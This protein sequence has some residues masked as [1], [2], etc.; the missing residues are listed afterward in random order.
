[1]PYRIE[2]NNPECA[3]GYAVVKES[4]G[5]L[6]FCHKSRREA[7]AQIAAIEA[8]ENYRALPDNYRPSSSENVLD[9]RACRNCV[10]YAGGYCS[11][12][13]AKVLASYYCNAWKGS[14]EIERAE[15][16][17][18]T[19]EMRAE[20]RRGLEWRRLYGRGGTEIGV[21]RARDIINGALSYDTVL[22]MRSFFARH[23][24]DK[25]GEGFSPNENG[26]PSAGRIAWALWGGDPGKVW[27]NKI[28][29]QDTD[30]MLAKSNTVGLHS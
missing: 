14:K 25:Q 15:S 19:Q 5:S 12:W 2:T 1:M 9:G 30:R 21:A 16:Y 7:K 11:K 13:D 20:A 6:V 10:Y 23:E 17:K 18:P 27:A 4:D 26:Y 28:I 29:S 8:S 3:S 24:V 22:R